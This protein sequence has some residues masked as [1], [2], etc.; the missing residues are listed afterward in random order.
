MSAH[1]LGI[2]AVLL[3]GLLG[4]MIERSGRVTALDAWVFVLF[5]FYLG[6]TGLGTVVQ[7]VVSTIINAVGGVK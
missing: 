1:L 2:P 6:G 3:F 5:G 7:N 4:W